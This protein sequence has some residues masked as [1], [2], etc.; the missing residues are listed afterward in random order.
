MNKNSNT[1]IMIYAT[2]MIVVVAVL[3]A[4]ASMSLADRKNANIVTEKQGA[5]LASMGLA[6]EADKAADKTAYIKGEYVRY[7]V[8]SYAVDAEGEKAEGADAFG[9]LENLKAEYAKDGAE[10]RLPVFEARLDDGTTLYVLPV[11]GAGLWGPIWGYIALQDD[12]D[13]IYGVSF[14]HKGETPGLG[15]EIATPDFAARFKGKKIFAGGKFAGISVIKGA[16][17]SAGKDNAVDAI[18]GGTITSRGVQ[19]MILSCLEDYLPLMEKMRAGRGMETTDAAVSTDAAE[20]G[21][22]NG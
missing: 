15:A 12:W 2:V 9:L 3:L 21:S 7:I 22:I 4:V 8:D 5:I 17:A 19:T 16:G 20:T 1:Y 13:T 10:R 18:S 14:D 11:Y 6:G